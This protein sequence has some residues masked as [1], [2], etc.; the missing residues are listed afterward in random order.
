[1]DID[2]FL[3]RE[4]ADLGVG[5]PAAEE[6]E[7]EAPQIKDG[8]GQS[9]L[10]ESA[11]IS[12]AKGNL[13]PAEKSYMQLWRLLAQQKLKWSKEVYEQLF[14]L[15]MHFSSTL[16]RA[17]GEVKRKR[18]RISELI[19]RGRGSLKE[20]KKDLPLKIYAE[21]Q[22]IN[23]SIPNVFFEE[24]RAINEQVISFYR[25]L[26][27]STDIDLIKKVSS[28]MQQINHLVDLINDS[29][30]ANDIA[31]ATANYLK[32]IEMYNQV[33]EGFLISK[34]SAG[35][36]LLGIYKTISIYSEI[37]ELQKQLGSPA[38]TLQQV[39]V[40]VSAPKE[41]PK[42]AAR[43]PPPKQIYYARKPKTPPKP[44]AVRV[45]PTIPPKNSLSNEKR[46][47]AKRNIKKG[48]YNEAW[49]D[50]EEAL[51]LDPSDVEAKALRAKIKTLQ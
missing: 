30:R 42:Y 41:I 8:S 1:M 15:G 29:I 4:L 24:K 11:S 25:E 9:P 38:V 46:E 36:K 34:N 17:Y 21:I 18:D 20:G 39:S 47:S 45:S 43:A 5:S 14:A 35:M 33:P 27:S 40:K 49:K 7:E 3:D 6:K 12:L 31:S 51:Q 2:E 23:N 13:E 10:V 16:N 19:G 22:E 48:F 50:I 26:T 44:A 37:S 32:C 28:Q